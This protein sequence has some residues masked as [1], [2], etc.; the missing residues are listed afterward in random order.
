LVSWSTPGQQGRAAAS[1][2]AEGAG[3]AAAAAGRLQYIMQ[4]AWGQLNGFAVADRLDM[5]Q[6][7]GLVNF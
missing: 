4:Q 6:P 1:A 2:T 5:C 7:H 3:Q